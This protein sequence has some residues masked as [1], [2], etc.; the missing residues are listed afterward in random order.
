VIEASLEHAPYT[1]HTTDFTI[2]EP[3]PTFPE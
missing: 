1:T 2:E 3:R